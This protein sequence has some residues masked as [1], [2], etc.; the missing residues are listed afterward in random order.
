[1]K[2]NG[3]GPSNIVKIY[4]DNKVKAS[5]SSE[6]AKSDSVQISQEGRSLS[7]LTTGTDLVSI[8]DPKHV[9][10]VKSQIE[11]GTYKPNSNQ[12]AQKMLDAI[13]GREA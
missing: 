2:L 7:N 3:I 1:M 13:K 6:V 8:S 10:A 12:I 4:N 9:E 5:K 11:Q